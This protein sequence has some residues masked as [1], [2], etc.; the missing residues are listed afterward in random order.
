[1]SRIITRL[2]IA[3]GAALLF[4][5]PAAAQANFQGFTN[6]CFY[7]TSA[8]ACT[9]TGTSASQQSTLVAGGQTRLTYQNSVFN[10]TSV[11]NTATFVPFNDDF[12]GTLQRGNGANPGFD[13]DPYSFLLRVTFTAPSGAS[14]AQLFTADVTGILGFSAGEAFIDFGGPQVF[15]YNGGTFSLTINDVMAG[16][17]PAYVTGTIALSPTATVPEPSTYALMAAGLAGLGLVA[18]RRRQA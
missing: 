15:S 6:G 3:A 14:P 10:I 8:G 13:L 17:S 7:L 9:V 5:S 18:R 4:A 2:A 11:G 16:F 12:L 1:M